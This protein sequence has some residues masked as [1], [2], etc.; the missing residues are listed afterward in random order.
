[1]IPF[2]T[3]I[4]EFLTAALVLAVPFFKKIEEYTFCVLCEEAR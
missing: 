2:L 3:E 4:A 1:M